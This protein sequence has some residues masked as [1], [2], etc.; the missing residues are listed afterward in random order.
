MQ[1]EAQKWKVLVLWLSGLLRAL[2]WELIEI[3]HNVALDLLRNSSDVYCDYTVLSFLFETK[4]FQ[5]DLTYKVVFREKP[6]R[7]IHLLFA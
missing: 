5:F 6:R 7:R 1:P 3:V 4:N 2:D